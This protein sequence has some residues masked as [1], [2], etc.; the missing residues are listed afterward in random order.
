[1]LIRVSHLFRMRTPEHALETDS[2]KVSTIPQPMEW[3]W[4]A[5]ALL[6]G[7]AIRL[8]GVHSESFSMDEVYEIRLAKSTV[9][10]ILTR[11]DGFPPLYHLLLHGIFQVTPSIDAARVFSIVIGL[12]VIIATWRIGRLISVPV[13]SVAALL[14]AFS[15]FCVHYSQEARAYSLFQAAAA[16]AVFSFLRALQTNRWRDWIAFSVLGAVT[17]Y[18]HYHAVALI[19]ATA[20]V[21]LLERPTKA[22]WIRVLPSVVLLGLLAS[23][24]TLVMRPDLELQSGYDNIFF[25]DLRA[26]GFTYLSQFAGTGIG[27]GPSIRSLHGMDSTAAILGFLPWIILSV[28]PLGLLGWAGLQKDQWTT[29]LVSLMILPTLFTGLIGWVTNSGFNPRYVNWASVILFVYLARGVVRTSSLP[30]LISVG[31]I[32]VLWAICHFNTR[33]VESYSIENSSA[34]VQFLSSKEARPVVVCSGYLVEPLRFYSGDRLKYVRCDSDTMDENEIIELIDNTLKS[35]SV[36]FVY[37]RPF[38][39]DPNGS[40]FNHLQ[41]Q[42]RDPVLTTAGYRVY[43]VD[44][45]SHAE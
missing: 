6:I 11:G 15:P 26:G 44:R 12:V 20:V 42:A 36:W 32:F 1:M 2:D 25:L 35:D 14:V 40:I 9:G 45:T 28:V 10:D 24:V 3:K 34:V 33:F 43:G 37:G 13:A 39:G 16:M 4:C 7:L 30:R 5:I 41:L 31:V 23:P 27:L 18:V 29:R 21:F 17:C 38:H 19:A 8:Y 22:Q